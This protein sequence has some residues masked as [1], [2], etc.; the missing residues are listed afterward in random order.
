MHYMWY[1]CEYQ[2]T[3]CSDYAVSINTILRKFLKEIL[4][5]TDQ[6]LRLRQIIG[7]AKIQPIVPVSA[8]TWWRGVKSGRF[9]KPVKLGEGR[10]TF[11][12]ASEVYALLK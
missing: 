12:K 1:Y 4:E 10:S 9:P 7:N 2:Y 6:F 11:W 8:A 3:T 5:M